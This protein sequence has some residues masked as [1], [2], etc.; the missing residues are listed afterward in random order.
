MPDS[1][2][3]YAL[4]ISKNF[5]E[6]YEAFPTK[7]DDTFPQSIRIQNWTANCRRLDKFPEGQDDCLYCLVCGS[8]VESFVKPKN[9][10]D[11]LLCP[12]RI[13]YFVSQGGIFDL[14]DEKAHFSIASPET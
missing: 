10:F 5:I 13:Y 8:S 1:S 4:A 6:G 2:D 11:V 12:A 9:L 7:W 14:S 3:G